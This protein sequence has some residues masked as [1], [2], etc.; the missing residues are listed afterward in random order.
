MSLQE[1]YI[2]ATGRDDWSGR[3]PDPNS[4]GTDGPFATIAGARD[5]I[6]KLKQS[7]MLA[8]PVTVWLRGGHYYQSEPVVFTPEDSAPVTFAA[9]PGE[10]PVVDG[11]VRIT[12]WREE[13]VGGIAMWVADVPGAAEGKRYFR[14]LFV[15]G[16][17]RL[18]IRLPEQG[19]YWM[20]DVPG[21]AIHNEGMTSDLFAGTD[22][23]VCAQ[24]DIDGSWSNRNDVDV[25]AVHYWIEERMPIASFDPSTGVVKSNRKSMFVLKDDVAKRYAKYYVENVFEAL[26]DPGQWY[27]DRT[28]GKVYYIPLP[29]EELDHT[30]FVAGSAYQLLKL[31]GNPDGKEYVEYLSFKGLTFAHTDWI[32]PQGGGERFDMPGIDFAAAP[33]A[34]FHIPGVI[35]M[36]GARYCSIEDCRVE[37]IGWYGIELSEGCMSNR[38]VGNT[39]ADMGAGGIKL[40]GADAD[41][42]I[43]RRTGGNRITDNHIHAGGNIFHSACGILSVHSFGNTISH[44][45]IHDL[46]YTG[47]SCGWVWGYGENVSRDNRIE[48]NHIH[49]IGHGLLSDMGGIY[50]LGVQPGTVIRG[51][52]IH[53]IEKC[54]YGG[55]AIYPD[56]GSSHIIIENNVCFKTSSQV[57]HQHYGR[58]NTVRN[59]IFAFGREGQAS[60]SRAEAHLSFT[61]ERNI[62][63]ADGQPLYVAGY[64]GRF[65]KKGFRSDLNLY[66][67]ISGNE[68]VSGNQRFD[69]QA[70]FSLNEPLSTADMK[71]LGYDLHSIHADPLFTDAAGGDFTL[72]ADSPA[73]ALGFQP[74]DLADVGPRSLEDR[75]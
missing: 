12:G 1:L 24:G 23:F 9:Y 32:Q 61:F 34:A 72:Q 48:K 44:N 74:I 66:W 7:A 49:D 63:V 55:W 58:E 73:F 5:S 50:T 6:R 64:S 15:N 18:R 60:L 40:D 10:R 4:D 19:F 54:N 39:I 33:Q 31:A 21:T 70:N 67:D 20:K 65:D 3:L 71:Q 69:E 17:R 25:V 37:R 51:N 13:T 68:L 16:E 11:G 52:L 14:Q 8:G 22:T 30:E 28:G 59:N 41:G 53:D 42:P 46:Y 56:E 38:I 43:L 2:S 57:F 62:I 36:R 26:T 75:E 35:H 45:H 47:I 27:L 29:G